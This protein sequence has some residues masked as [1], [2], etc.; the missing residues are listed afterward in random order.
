MILCLSSGSRE[1]YRQDVILSLAMPEDHVLQFRYDMNWV[2]PIILDKFKNNSIINETALIAYLDQSDK[3]KEP[4]LI[5]CRLAQ[6]INAAT[7]GSTVSL[8][9]TLG[10]FAYASD[11][12][13][14]NH[15]IRSL[16]GGTV[17]DWGEAG[18]P[19]GHYCVWIESQK[20]STVVTSSELYVWENIVK[21]IAVR[22]DFLCEKCFY[23]V[24]SIVN[25][26]FRTF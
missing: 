13:A 26:N 10:E 25:V 6:I 9:F 22:N 17:P 8:Q 12:Q 23:I 16:P 7:H 21:H 18:K 14:L 5:P 20:L 19:R 11:I 15:E 3:E 24:D 1:R 4:E 2:S